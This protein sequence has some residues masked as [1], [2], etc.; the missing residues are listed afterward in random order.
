[1]KNKAMQIDT[2]TQRNALAGD[3]YCV[4]VVAGMTRPSLFVAVA[5]KV[6]AFIEG[7]DTVQDDALRRHV[8]AP[9]WYARANYDIGIAMREN[10]FYRHGDVWRYGVKS[11]KRKKRERWKLPGR[12]D[13][14]AIRLDQLAKLHTMV[15]DEMKRRGR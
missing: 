10:G 11:E 14:K 1:M 7:L 9:A 4:C 6:D 13:L 5:E 3:P 12:S 2:E 8:N 15:E